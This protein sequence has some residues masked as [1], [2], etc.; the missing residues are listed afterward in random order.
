[1]RVCNIDKSKDV[2]DSNN[3]E[4]RKEVSIH[5]GNIDSV[6]VI[7]EVQCIEK[8]NLDEVWCINEVHILKERI[9]KGNCDE[10]DVDKVHFIDRK[11]C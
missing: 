11:K 10:N 7:V 8:Q 3:E 2:K 9:D 5:E 6:N 4:Y 1:M